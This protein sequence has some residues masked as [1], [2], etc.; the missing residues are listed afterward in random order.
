MTAVN[1]K[2]LSES[3]AWEL[4]KQEDVILERCSGHERG[5]CM[6]R[7]NTEKL[8]ELLDRILDGV[9]V[10]PTRIRVDPK[11]GAE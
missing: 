4:Q 8:I 11:G 3:I 1:H 7:I 9:S 10:P 2:T 5:D 6:A